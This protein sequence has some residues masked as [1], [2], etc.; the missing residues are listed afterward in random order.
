MKLLFGPT[1][2]LFNWMRNYWKGR[3]SRNLTAMLIIIVY[4]L[5]LALIELGR[6]GIDAGKLHRPDAQEPLCIHQ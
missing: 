2:R 4:L 1:N 3:Y 5:S 6:R